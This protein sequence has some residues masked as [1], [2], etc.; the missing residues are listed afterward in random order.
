MDLERYINARENRDD[1]NRVYKLKDNYRKLGVNV[2]MDD[3]SKHYIKGKAFVQE[4]LEA[5]D[6][7]LE[8]LQKEFDEI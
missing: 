1:L 6:A 2:I 8:R 3:G 7:E 5:C 4:L